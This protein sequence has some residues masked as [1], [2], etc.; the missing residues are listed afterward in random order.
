[1]RPRPCAL[2][3]AVAAIALASALGG[4]APPETPKVSLPRADLRQAFLEAM[5]NEARDPLAAY[6]YLEAVELAVEQSDEPWAFATLVASL[7]AL[8]S[9]SSPSMTGGVEHVVAYRSN[10]VLIE[11]VRRLKGAW[12]AASAA[13]PLYRSMIATSLH[14]L[15]LRVGNVRAARRWRARAGC[16][17]EASV[18]GPLDEEPLAGLAR[19]APLPA[20]G[21]MPE[22]TRGV[23]P[24]A[25]ELR[26]ERV[27]ANACAIDV[28]QP[29]P[30]RGLYA[31]ALDLEVPESGRVWVLWSSTTAAEVELAGAPLLSRSH[32]AGGDAVTLVASARLTP[33]TARLVARVA[34]GDG[35]AQVAVRVLADD[36][37]P[38]PTHAPRGGDEAQATPALE[39]APGPGPGPTLVPG[40]LALG[41]SHGAPPGALDDERAFVL[42]AATLLGLGQPR[43]AYELLE[44]PGAPPRAGGDAMVDLL[45]I[46]AIQ[47]AAELPH[48]Q[49]LI[50]VSAAAERVLERC[51]KCWEAR[52]VRAAA[53]H[54][55]S[56]HSV[57]AYAALRSLGVSATRPAGAD[58]APAAE[59]AES[60]APPGVAGAAEAAEDGPR[61]WT[62]ELDVLGLG[63]VAALAHRSGLDDVAAR[64][65]AALARKTPGSPMLADV[66]ALVHERVGDDAVDAACSGGTSRGGMR[67]LSAYSD[68]GD[69]DQALRE[70]ER[71]RALRGTRD[72]LKETELR[73]LLEQGRVDDAL[74][75]YRSLPPGR[76]S[77]AVLG[78]GFGTP[79]AAEVKAHFARDMRRARD[80]P[81][82]F[83][84][85]ARLLGVVPDR[86]AE[87]EAT[88]KALVRAD[89]ANAFLP[90]AATAILRH[91]E[92]YDLDATGLL[93]FWIYDLRRVSSTTDV[94][95]GT[96]AGHPMITGRAT[97]RT[98]RRRIHKAD[99][100]VLDPDPEA[101]AT[102]GQGH[103]ELSQLEAGDYVEELLTGWAMPDDSGQLVVDTADLLPMRRSVREAEI[104]FARPSALGL[105][106]WTH[107]LL[108][109]GTSAEASGRT[110]TLWR[111]A[112]QPPRRMEEGVPAL[113]QRVGLSFGTESWA[114]MARAIADKLAALDDRDP[115]ASHNFLARWLATEA[116]GG[117]PSSAGARERLARVVAAVG[118]AIPKPD[119][120]A[121]AD[122]AAVLGGSS[123]QEG[124]R[125]YLEQ[126]TG[127]RTW[128]VYRAL[129]ELG[130]P[131]VI[132]VAETS[133][134]S[135]A[136]GFPPRAGRFRHPLVRATVDGAELWVD[137]DV[138]GPPLPPGTVSNE[139]RGRQ[140]LLTTGELVTVESAGGD[141]GDEVD[142]R[143]VVDD[144]GDATGTFAAVLR[145]R[146]AQKLSEAFE[147][148]VGT[149]KDEL[150][151]NVVLGWL[152][153]ADVRS[154]SLSSAPGAWEIALRADL[155]VPG[156]ARPE[157]LAAPGPRAPGKPDPAPASFT[158]P[159][160]EPFHAVFPRAVATTLGARYTAQPGRTTAIAIDTPQ[161]FH[162]RRRVELPAGFKVVR[163]PP[164][165]LLAA[166]EMQARR[167]LTVRDGAVEEDFVL[168]LPV[169]SVQPD[170]LPGFT[171]H[172]RAVDEGFLYGIRIAR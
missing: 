100:R 158:L 109:T 123:R 65:F 78:V 80:A 75:I 51:P 165:F 27:E 32:A 103:T 16:A 34:N 83:E 166:P 167:T 77:L 129:A 44:G 160:V 118:H 33:G 13:G 71:L 102:G 117:E 112:N 14:E 57:G 26:P 53:A 147:T 42:G 157:G 134:F 120:D 70:V 59:P 8:V 113:E 121:L 9:R 45:R 18:V 151:R 17:P 144:K 5:R 88:G 61:G 137:A 11:T 169:G 146:A 92:D 95:S 29:S 40:V 46:R 153:W 66:D 41:P 19:P 162:V 132:A 108:G 96:G 111:L 15:A 22:R 28:S 38:V 72:Y 138:D 99:G 122:F 84:P 110:T 91:V 39:P 140:A 2:V 24:F 81:F 131:A 21:P 97:E 126:G 170:A 47:Q 125:Y 36:G 50:E 145:G 148:V 130:I 4:C 149:G 156:F 58:T 89:R 136:P 139:L 155:G 107:A 6:G 152:P 94:A 90:G 62:E 25:A 12:K 63:Y 10:E 168:N 31:L 115:L 74:A 79:L 3:A 37:T 60:A 133:P 69:F 104:R 141:D 164:P 101:T 55:R 105:A 142:V 68:R 98:V 93:R 86:A 1:M 7:D 161:L 23:P 56:G 43:L 116:F 106:L 163:E 67:C 64:A 143:L 87:L 73:I 20:Q 127:S 172:V 135:A 171:G 35:S 85:L 159:G 76:R 119:G 82:A 30:L 124:A 114:R 49:A 52:L 54:E 154:V 128:V 150:L 48:S